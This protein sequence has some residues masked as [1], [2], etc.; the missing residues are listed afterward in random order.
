MKKTVNR[1]KIAFAGILLL[2]VFAACKKEKNPV[3]NPPAPVVEEELITTLK[4]TFTDSSGI[5]PDVIAMF[6]DIDG[7]GGNEPTA[8]D[9]IRLKANATYFASIQVLN[10]S[11][12]PAED[13]TVEI[14]DEAASHLICFDIAGANV[15]VIRTDTDGVYEVG[16]ISKW[17]TGNVSM[18]SSVIS[19]KHQPGIKNGSCAVGETDIEV[20][21]PTIIE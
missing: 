4:V 3:S 14:L 8:M 10:E 15:Q 5:H 1:N 19:L 13:I 18:G 16:V 17:T 7:P 20:N 6:Q 2:F 12:N 9:T 11:I 21:F